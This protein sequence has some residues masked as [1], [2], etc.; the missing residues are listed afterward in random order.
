M[1]FSLQSLQPEDVRLTRQVMPFQFVSEGGFD[2]ERMCSP[3][4]D[5]SCGIIVIMIM[6]I[7]VINDYDYNCD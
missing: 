3:W 7:I 6:I 4:E 2:V 5:G 1:S